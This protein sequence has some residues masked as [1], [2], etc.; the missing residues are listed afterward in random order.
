M[1]FDTINLITGY[2]YAAT[3]PSQSSS[4]RCDCD[5]HCIIGPASCDNHCHLYRAVGCSL[6][7]DC[8]YTTPFLWEL[9]RAKWT[10][11]ELLNSRTVYWH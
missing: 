4:P 3:E 11:L 10:G 2:A 8:S 5:I 7:T 9:S 6:A 1:H